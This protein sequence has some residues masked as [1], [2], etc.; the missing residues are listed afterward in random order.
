MSIEIPKGAKKADL[1]DLLQQASFEN[2]ALRTRID[3]LEKLLEKSNKLN[4]KKNEGK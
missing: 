1:L 3:V 2:T 4:D